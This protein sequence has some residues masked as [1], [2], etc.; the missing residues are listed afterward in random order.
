MKKEIRNVYLIHIILKE[1]NIKLF[2][3]INKYKIKCIK[4][5]KNSK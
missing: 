1:A 2:S 4:H 3:N 5:L